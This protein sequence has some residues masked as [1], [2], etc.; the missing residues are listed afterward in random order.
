MARNLLNNIWRLYMAENRK[1]DEL[2]GMYLKD[3]NRI[4]MLSREEE[5]ELAQKAKAGDKNAK[6]KIVNANLRFV[7]SIA[8]KY[9][10][11]GMDLLDL[12]SEGNLGL[13]NAIELFDID[14]G[15]HF[16]SYAVWWIRQSILKALSEK[17]RPIRLPLNRANELIQI[18]KARKSIPVDLSEEE[19]LNEVANMLSLRPEIVK[20]LVNISK[21]TVSLDT[22]ISTIE[23]DS[24]TIGDLLEDNMYER[25]ED[26]AVRINMEEKIEEVLGTLDARDAEVLR[27]RYGLSGYKQMS[28]KEVG[29]TFNLTK[30]R[31]RQIEKKA[32]KQMQHPRRMSMLA[33]FV[34]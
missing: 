26:A 30:E 8:K 13:L 19:E 15:Y 9:Q 28:L 4:P 34:A 17:T 7:V 27:F 3:I 24:A 12:I 16:I 10:N 14:K 22:S 5:V 20:D 18:E 33:A 21:D 32:I 25:P 23:K 1:N 2:V 29:A 6:D 11:Q 31:I